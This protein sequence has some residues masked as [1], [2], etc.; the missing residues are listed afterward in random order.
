LGFK[1]ANSESKAKIVDYGGGKVFNQPRSSVSQNAINDNITLSISLQRT[2]KPYPM[3]IKLLLVGNTIYK[4]YGNGLN[5]TGFDVP[6]NSWDF[7]DISL[8]NG[9]P[10]EGTIQLGHMFMTK[11]DYRILVEY[12]MILKGNTF[13]QE[14]SVVI[15]L[16]LDLEI[17]WVT[18]FNSRLDRIRRRLL[19][20]I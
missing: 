11:E 1:S 2:T 14:C 9:A 13:C 7:A 8:T 6:N 5:A 3:I 16:D 12:N 4:E 18:F 17:K 20:R 10:P 19:W 15:R